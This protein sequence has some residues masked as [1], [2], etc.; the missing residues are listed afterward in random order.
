MKTL[1]SIAVLIAVAVARDYEYKDP[2]M[3]YQCWMPKKLPEQIEFGRKTCK[4]RGAEIPSINSTK[5]QDICKKG[6]CGFDEQ[7]VNVTFWLDNDSQELGKDAERVQTE[8]GCIDNEEVDPGSWC[9][10]DCTDRANCTPK[11]VEFLDGVNGNWGDLANQTGFLRQ[12]PCQTD[13]CNFVEPSPGNSDETSDG[14]PDGTNTTPD[15]GVSDGSSLTMGE[16]KH[17]IIA[18]LVGAIWL[19]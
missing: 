16:K 14:T 11:R 15:S 12:C 10:P 19:H 1:L 13:L 7:C 18:F 9:L 4:F 6:N 3:D 5:F 17:L 8:L 2:N